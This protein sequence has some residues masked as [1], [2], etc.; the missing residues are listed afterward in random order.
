M[1]KR[2]WNSLH[3]PMLARKKHAWNSLQG[4]KQFGLVYKSFQILCFVRWTRAGCTD[5]YLH[6]RIP[7]GGNHMLYQKNL[8]LCT[9]FVH[10]LR[11]NQSPL[12]KHNTKKTWKKTFFVL[13]FV[14]VFRKQET[15]KLS[16]TS[17]IN[18]QS[19]S[20]TAKIFGGRSSPFKPMHRRLPPRSIPHDYVVGEG[21]PEWA[22]ERAAFEA[23][24]YS[25]IGSE[26]KVEVFHKDND[27]Q[28]EFH[29]FYLFPTCSQDTHTHKTNFRLNSCVQPS[30]GT[31]FRRIPACW[32]GNC[33]GYWKLF[34][35]TPKVCFWNK[36]QFLRA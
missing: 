33:Y 27:I 13:Q 35:N 23:S 11:F 30:Q 28:D 15:N 9:K 2:G 6:S 24:W 14:W 7:Y 22:T 17:S 25:S 16:T 20:S 36:Q 5:G 21:K 1:E 31:I 10:A 19:C 26:T 34:L 18:Q 29:E 32:A 8:T 4:F 3:G 12:K